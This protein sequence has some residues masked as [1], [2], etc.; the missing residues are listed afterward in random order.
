MAGFESIVRPVVFPNIRP[1][2]QQSVRPQE[3]ASDD[4]DKGVCKISGTSGKVVQLPYSFSFS[5]SKSKPAE[6]KR[7]SDTA[8]VS[9]EEDDG[10]INKENFV[11]VDVANKLWMEG[12]K[13]PASRDQAD[14]IDVKA[15]QWEEFY[16]RQEAAD[17]IELKEKDKIKKA[18]E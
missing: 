5:M 17:N 18:P 9:Q 11:D 10:T 7:R 13:Q 1:T 4:E 16:Q 2:P 6:K 3:D 15:A 12:G 14:S 8:R